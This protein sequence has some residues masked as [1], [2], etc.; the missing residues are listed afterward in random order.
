MRIQNLNPQKYK[1]F[2]AFGCSF[3]NYKWPTWSDIIGSHVPYYRNWGKQ[4]GGNHYIFNSIVEANQ[5]YQF[6]KDD[7]V[8]VMWSSIYREDRYSGTG[9]QNDTSLS[10]E[11]T[12]GKSWVKKYGT[13][14]RG[15]MIRDFAMIRAAQILLKSTECDWSH[16]NIFPLVNI[17]HNIAGSFEDIKEEEGRAY[18]IEIYNQ[19]CATGEVNPYLEQQ[20]ILKTYKDIFLDF[21]PHIDFNVASKSDVHPSPKEALVFLQKTYPNNSLSGEWDVPVSRSFSRL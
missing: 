1:R 5:Q 21:E 2:F 13:D 12:Y 9:W 3:T 7:L 10:Q 20:D 18:H 17:D 8:M 16:L 14:T 4:G 11:E 6:N 15:F 19:M